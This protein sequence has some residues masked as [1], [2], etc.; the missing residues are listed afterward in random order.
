MQAEANRSGLS[1]RAILACALSLLLLV[2]AA[3]SA[4]HSLHNTL[5]ATDSRD[6]S[7]CLVCAFAQGQVSVAEAA[8]A[9]L[10][11]VLFVLFGVAARDP[12]WLPGGD[13][14]LSPSRAPPRR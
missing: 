5:H 2:A 8:A 9:T 1:A 4:S 10:V 6:H 7:V 11:V 3:A 13:Y 14:R 12:E